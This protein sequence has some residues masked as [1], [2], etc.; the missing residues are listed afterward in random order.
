M[1][2]VNLQ[3]QTQTH[4]HTHA[5]TD[6]HTHINTLQYV[7]VQSLW[8]E[9]L[10]LLHIKPNYYVLNYYQSNTITT[11][12][13]VCELLCVKPHYY[14]SNASS[15]ITT[16]QLLCVLLYITWSYY[17][18]ITVCIIMHQAKLLCDK[19]WITMCQAK[20]LPVNYYVY[21]MHQVKLPCD[22][23][24]VYD[25]TLSKITMWQALSSYVTSKITTCQSKLL[26]IEQN[27]FDT[28]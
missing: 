3:T 4:I 20:L 28:Q 8:V 19:H 14:V 11:C 22:N 10:E 17:L 24:Y 15:K 12:Q 6:T 2:A 13:L 21:Y 16:C 25:Y 26:W 5:D 27:Y 9:L 18:S 1:R 7:A 23:S